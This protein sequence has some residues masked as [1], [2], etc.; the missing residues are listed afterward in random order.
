M[1]QSASVPLVLADQLMPESAPLMSAPFKKVRLVAGRDN[2]FDCVS[3]VDSLCPTP[4]RLFRAEVIAFF[5]L[6]AGLV[7]DEFGKSLTEKN[8]DF[9]LI[10]TFRAVKHRPFSEAKTLSDGEVLSRDSLLGGVGYYFVKY[11]PNHVPM[12]ATCN[13][14]GRF[15]IVSLNDIK[16]VIPIFPFTRLDGTPLIAS[17]PNDP[18]MSS[19]IPGRTPKQLY[20]LNTSLY[21]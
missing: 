11:P 4:T 21:I 7:H 14:V 10:G 9:A 20:F 2:R 13:E 5:R 18:T 19:T 16:S 1:Y 17:Y 3:A 15:R 12:P 8:L 6:E